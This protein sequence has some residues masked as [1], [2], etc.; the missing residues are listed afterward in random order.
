MKK[1]YRKAWF[2]ATLIAACLLPLVATAQVEK[3]RA[4]IDGMV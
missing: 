4:R 2:A 1:R 3:A